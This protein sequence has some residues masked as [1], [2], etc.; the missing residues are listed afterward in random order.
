VGAY[1]RDPPMPDADRA[2]LRAAAGE[3]EATFHDEVVHW[4]RE[5][6]RPA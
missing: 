3:K 1:M 2:P 4:P 5:R 6:L